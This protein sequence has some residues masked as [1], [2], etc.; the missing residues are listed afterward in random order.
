MM[1]RSLW[2]SATGMTA[3]QFDLDV[4]ANNLANVNTNGYKRSRAD[5]QDLLY[6]KIRLP[7]VPLAAALVPTGIEVGNGVGVV[8]TQRIFV[9]G[10]LENTNNALDIAI[11]GDGFF[12]VILPDG[13]IAYTRDGSFV[14][15]NEGRI[16]TKDGYILEPEIII[17]A[18]AT[19][20]SITEEGKVY[21]VIAGDMTAVEEVGSIELARFINP[22]GLTSIGKNLFQATAA[23]GDAILGEPGLAGFG[24]LRQKFI[25]KSNVNVIDE[26][27]KMIMVQR[28]YEFNSRAIQT[29]DNMLGAVSGLKR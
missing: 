13:S 3:Q 18:D 25:E 24:R 11:E 14:K 1:V 12:K 5:F 10:P 20:I 9:L 17:P 4:I 8:G 2:T 22:A 28:A 21:V 27:V 26:M 29:V 23:S 7:G 19:D 16:V 15:D 6:E